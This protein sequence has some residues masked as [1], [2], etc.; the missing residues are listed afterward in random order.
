MQPICVIGSLNVDLTV[1]LPRF[2]LPGETI[3]GTAFNTYAGGKGGNQAVAAARL[4]AAVAMVGKLGNDGNGAFYRHTLQGHGVG[5]SGVL[6]APEAPT[7]VALIEVDAAGE[8]RIALVPGANALVDRAQIDSLGPLLQKHRIFL[9]QLEIPMDVTVYAADLLG[10]RGGTLLLDPAPAVPLPEGLYGHVDCLTP[11][12]TELALLSGLPAGSPEEAEQAARALLR[13]G[14]KA[15][16]AKLGGKG[17]LYVDG[18]RT[19]RAP[20]FQ[21]D[22][23]DTTAAGDSFNAGFAVA[24]AMDWPL[25]EALRFANAVGALSTTGKGAQAAMPTMAQAL[26][27]LR[28]KSGGR[29]LPPV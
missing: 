7:G 18:E 17:C 14:A 13:R 24:L 4:G 25:E 8:N 21:V 2:H 23:V 26:A 16:L 5:L 20:G 27:F 19:L 15:V 28:E 9:L 10:S 3:T 6:T 11:N 1:T 29:A 12:E 22:V